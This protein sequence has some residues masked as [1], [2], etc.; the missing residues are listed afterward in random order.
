M[1]IG[2]GVA[3]AGGAISM[4]AVLMKWLSVAYNNNNQCVAHSFMSQQITEIKDWL[5]RVEGKLDGVI[6]RAQR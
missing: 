4:A 6:E 3:I 2:T 1:D 5:K